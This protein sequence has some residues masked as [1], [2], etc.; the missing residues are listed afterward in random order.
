MSRFRAAFAAAVVSFGAIAP[1]HAAAPLRLEDAF[2]RVIES[3]PDL[4][5]WRARREALQAERDAA[6]LPPPVTANLSS[7][8][9]PG[10]GNASGF[11]QAELT[12]SL[13]SVLERGGKREA[14][15][16]VASHRLDAT[17]VLQEAR[18]IDLLAEVARRYLDA[19]VAGAEA[20]LAAADV[21]QR[22]RTLEAASKRVQAGGAP[23]SVRL[24]ALAAKQRAESDLHRAERAQT[25]AKRRL[26]LLWGETRGASFDVTASDFLRLPEVVAYEDLKQ[27]LAKN[28]D[29]EVFGHEAR[30]REARLR[31]AETARSRDVAWQVGVRRLQDGADWALVGNV[32]V[33]LGS[34]QRAE[35]AIRAAAAELDALSMEREATRLGLEAALAE[36]HG[37]IETAIAEAEQ[38]D[39]VLLP[40]LR[41]AES[42]AEQA[43]RRGA[44]TY[45]EWAELQS[46]I[47]ATQH[48]R[49]AASVEAHSALIELQR[50]TGEPMLRAVD[51]AKEQRR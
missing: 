21:A 28:P 10:T 24:A 40:T 16:E 51:P 20:R 29:L 38:F 36:A 2:Q 43:Y 8:N 49:L 3:H 6:A 9:A 47:I 37:R 50:L 13:A 12:V 17:A 25:V 45:L 15:V 33:P 31:L 34:M 11:Q 22:E 46:D 27:R 18:R 39:R 32:S 48:Q 5:V 19:V 44:L 30:I 7:E 14:R 26:S 4:A 35:P 42:S 1:T 23:Q 41:E